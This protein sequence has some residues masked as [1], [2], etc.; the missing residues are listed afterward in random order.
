MPL[1]A[2]KTVKV[3][4]RKECFMECL[5]DKELCHPARGFT[6]PRGEARKHSTTWVRP[7]FGRICK[8]AN[9]GG[10]WG[11]NLIHTLSESCQFYYQSA[12]MPP[13]LIYNF[14]LVTVSPSPLWIH[15]TASLTNSSTRALAL[16][17][18]FTMAAALPIR[19]GRALSIVCI[20][21]ST[22]KVG[23]RRLFN[24]P[25]H[26]YHHPRSQSHAQQE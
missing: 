3:N 17:F 6:L 4:R 15:A 24:I 12:A 1:L 14:A 25:H 16:F 26:Q 9:M 22:S 13:L 23:W 2:R 10:N 5:M 11:A 7:V 19:K 21:I 18:S 8:L 20:M